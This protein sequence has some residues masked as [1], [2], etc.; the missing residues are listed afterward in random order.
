MGWQD[1][2]IS[3]APA[4]TTPPGRPPPAEW[5]QNDPTTG[6]A[7]T[8]SRGH[9]PIGKRYR[10]Q[11]E[12]LRSFLKKRVRQNVEVIEGL[13]NAAT[14]AVVQ[15]VGGTTLL[16][17]D[18]VTQGSNFIRGGGFSGYEN[19]WDA[20]NPWAPDWRPTT[21]APMLELP[22]HTLNRLLDKY[23]TPP[24]SGWGRAAEFVSSS[25]LGGKTLPKVRSSV[26][27]APNPRMPSAVPEEIIAEGVKHDVPVF[28]DDVLE[29]PFA[30]RIGVT[31]EA[32]GPFGT[33][34]GR[35]A[36]HELAKEAARRATES[37]AVAGVDDLTVEVQK[38]LKRKL[39]ALKRVKN[40]LYER[41]A[42]RLDPVGTVGVGG[43]NRRFAEIRNEIDRLGPTITN[44]DLVKMLR[45]L[46]TGKPRGNFS[47]MMALSDE[48]GAR[49]TGYYKGQNA[50][51]GK[52]GVGYL[53][54]LKKALDKDIAAFADEFGGPEG[55]R[56][57][58][59]ADEFYKKHLAPYKE[60][61][62]RDLVRTGEP[63]KAWK[64][65]TGQGAIPS[66]SQRMFNALDEKGRATV[67]YGLLKEAYTNALGPKGQFSP[68]KFA[69]Y[70]DEHDA[71]VQQ[72][73]KGAELKEIQGFKNLMR[74]VDRAGSYAENPPTGQRLFLPLLFGSGYYSVKLPALGVGAGLGVRI[75]FQTERGRDLLLQM[76]KAKPGSREAGSL[77][78]T[79]ARYLTSTMTQAKQTGHP[80]RE[81]INAM[82]EEAVTMGDYERGE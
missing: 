5:W 55:S 77:S 60:P 25:L 74:H 12:R 71:A 80:D 37:R 35:A 10:T 66:R 68:A 46:Y 82:M 58:K 76:A 8:Q 51:I 50:T 63:E 3:R 2:P 57:F 67:R 70:I 32:M 18:V 4:A 39:E 69:T 62:F 28:A 81:D 29:S 48:L 1:D 53:I 23:T 78:N 75:L 36:Q 26:P 61:G 45:E 33:G 7:V 20:L 42:A 24:E 65:L 9:G 64:Y 30:K 73:F 27:T 43:F 11:Q 13:P 59:Q 54:D 14:R 38:G 6:A 40:Q 17:F 72:F 44:P 49:I 31:A 34:S 56:A 47:T 15:G 52:R 22:G 19:P 16:P 41:A 21:N 79:V